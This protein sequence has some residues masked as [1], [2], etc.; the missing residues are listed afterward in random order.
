M[1]LTKSSGIS[2]F[3]CPNDHQLGAAIIFDFVSL[4]CPL[5]FLR[6]TNDVVVVVTRLFPSDEGMAEDH[7]AP[8]AGQLS[9]AWARDRREIESRQRVRGA[10]NP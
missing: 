10:K 9:R 5:L 4:L 6:S 7:G 1:A 2:F 8:K 3:Y